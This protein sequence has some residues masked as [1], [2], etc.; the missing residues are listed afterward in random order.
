[1]VEESKVTPQ[2]RNYCPP[3]YVDYEDEDGNT[4]L[5]GWRAEENQGALQ[6]VGRIGAN[7]PTRT[8]AQLRDTLQLF[9]IRSWCESCPL[10][11]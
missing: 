1:M 11:I 9:R 10:A 4:I 2:R 5:G 3:A 8:A 6:N 7:N